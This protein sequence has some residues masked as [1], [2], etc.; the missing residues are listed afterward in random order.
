MDPRT[1]RP[2]EIFLEKLCQKPQ[3]LNN[4]TG[5]QTV[6]PKGLDCPPH[7]RKLTFLKIFNETFLSFEIAT[8]LNVMHANS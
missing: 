6:R 8:H 2:K 7:N 3:I 4:L 5:P 1:V